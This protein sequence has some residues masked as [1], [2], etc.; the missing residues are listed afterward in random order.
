MK[1]IAITILSVL[2]CFA[3][4]ICGSGMQKNIVYADNSDAL[5]LSCKAYVLADYKSGKVI[6]ENNSHARL[7][8]A[9]MV[10]MMTIL[11]TF[12]EIDIGNLK[13]DSTITTTE[14]AS[15][16]G[17]SQVFTDPFENYKVED[18]IKSVIISSANDAS[19]ALTE[20]I[21][22]N[23]D[24][25]VQKMNKR[26]NE[27]NM[28]DTVYANCTGLP[29]PE[30]Y[31]SAYDSYLILSQILNHD[32][33]HKYSTIW[34]DK[35]VHPSGRETELVNTNKLIR[36]YKG[37]DGGKTGSTNE[38]GYCLSASASRNDMRL[39]SVVVGAKFGQ[40]R[41]K[42][43][44]SL[45]NYGFANF[46]N[47]KLVDKNIKLSTIEIKMAK[48]KENDIF[49]NED[50]YALVKKNDNTEYS[51]SCEIFDNL[52]APLRCGTNVGKLYVVE[53]GK[54]VK[55]IDIVITKQIDKLTYK[56]TL[57]EIASNW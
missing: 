3:F 32:I 6:Y 37:C 53:E 38:A 15:K 23:E 7:P 29:A 10:K 4:T 51:I 36:Y 17:G 11:L 8:V 9:S 41:F 20:E 1:K 14:N 50:Y 13:L 16:M 52:K 27:L 30:Q 47:K 49:P 48:Q 26:A 28:N 35:L 24:V 22:G 34:M 46:E 12:E 42:E 18:L 56:D 19:V 44:S 39:I 55:E 33:Y 43:A 40:E 25:F 31:S 45:F 2:C 21:A 54:V 57:K 5:N